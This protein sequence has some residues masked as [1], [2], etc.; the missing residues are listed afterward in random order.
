MKKV[1]CLSLCLFMAFGVL[2]TACK[3]SDEK[4]KLD[5][6]GATVTIMAQTTARDPRKDENAK[7]SVTYE[8]SVSH[9]N[10]VEADFNCKIDVKS[11]NDWDALDKDFLTAMAAGAPP[12]DFISGDSA[13]GQP[14]YML[15]GY[16]LPL[17]D[18]M[19][20]YDEGGTGSFDKNFSNALTYDGKVYMVAAKGERPGENVLFFNKRI[21]KENPQLKDY[22][23]YGMSKKGEMTWD[24]FREIAMKATVD[25]NGDGTTDIMG[26]ASQGLPGSIFNNAIVVSNGNFYI[27]Y[28][29]EL[30]RD[31]V[32]LNNESGMRA[33]NF[34][35]DLAMKDKVL[36]ISGPYEGDWLYGRTAFQRAEAAMFVGGIGE[37]TQFTQLKTTDKYGFLP[38]P[39]GP[40]AGK[41]IKEISKTEFFAAIHTT[42]KAD[43]D[44]LPNKCKVL[45][46]LIAPQDWAVPFAESWET[47]CCDAEDVDMLD[48][49]AKMENTFTFYQGYDQ[50]RGA[51]IWSSCGMDQNIPPSTYVQEQLPAVED[52]INTM[53]D[54][55]AQ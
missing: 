8:K 36:G 1:F 16:L 41:V 6:K 18:W 25:T 5:L 35:F 38:I 26:I 27:E 46:A 39:V 30:G 2:F 43:L 4:T 24:K 9:I 21:F 55:K 42:N 12:A 13:V 37:V 14:K 31:K 47:W 15:N 7:T 52:Q 51:F 29:K 3:G 19:N 11:Q 17:N 33:L 34:T 40:D 49:F 20:V 32:I 22:D 28:D 10:Q 50:L 45:E 23:M 53:W 54:Q 48:F 44:N